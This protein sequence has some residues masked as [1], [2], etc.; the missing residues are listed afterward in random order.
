[1]SRQHALAWRANSPP[2]APHI[3]HASATCCCVKPALAAVCACGL[4]LW[5]SGAPPLLTPWSATL[6]QVT[7]EARGFG[8]V[9]FDQSNATEAAVALHGTS[10]DPAPDAARDGTSAAAGG[11]RAAG[12]GPEAKPLHVAYRC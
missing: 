2:M 11:P 4:C 12:D 6:N 5:A 1:M 10:F 3:V 8:F 9:T 7:G